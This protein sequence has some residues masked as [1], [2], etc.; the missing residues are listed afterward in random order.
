MTIDAY[1][2]PIG[3]AAHLD[4][5]LDDAASIDRQ[6]DATNSN[7]TSATTTAAEAQQTPRENPHAE[8]L[9]LKLS[10]QV[11]AEQALYDRIALDLSLIGATAD[12]PTQAPLPLFRTDHLQ[13][14]LAG[15]EVQD[16]LDEVDYGQ[17]LT[18]YLRGRYTAWNC[19]NDIYKLTEIRLAGRG[20][21]L[22]GNVEN[23]A[24][25]FA[26]HGRYHGN[27]LANEYRSLPWVSI[28]SGSISPTD[29]VSDVCV[30]AD[31]DVYTYVFDQASGSGCA[32][33][34]CSLHTYRGFTTT[35]S[36]GVMPLGTM[37]RTSASE[38]LPPWLANARDCTDLLTSGHLLDL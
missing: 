34:W 31:G 6:S 35:A 29:D 15:P 13:V 26:F 17:D 3:D 7:C 9:A 36:G 37:E 1:A 27:A 4:A 24:F 5:A 10:G 12:P 32:S 18:P 21:D 8:V 2:T 14:N 16:I 28:A 19:L 11:V 33:G 22:D 25:L 38:Q 30:S 20:F 23:V